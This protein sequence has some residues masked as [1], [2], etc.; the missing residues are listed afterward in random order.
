LFEQGTKN[1]DLEPA[2]DDAFHAASTVIG[3]TVFYVAALAPLI[4]SAT[5]KPLSPEQVAAHKRDTLRTV[6]LLLGIADPEPARKKTA[7]RT[8][9]KARRVARGG[10]VRSH[11]SPPSTAPFLKV[12]HEH[13]RSRRE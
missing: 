10:V 3:G 8:K 7:H 2:V 4:P 11:R 1:G 9:R 6:R 5:F 12:R 13:R